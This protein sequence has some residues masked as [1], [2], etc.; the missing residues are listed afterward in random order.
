[1][2]YTRLTAAHDSAF[3]GGSVHA[4]LLHGD[5]PTLVDAPPMDVAFLDGIDQ[6][7]RAARD[8]P[9]APIILPHAH[10][11]PTDGATAVHSRW[12]Q[13]VCRKRAPM[14]EGGGIDWQVIEKEPMRP[15]GDGEL[16][17]LHTPGHAPDHSCLFDIHA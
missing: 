14:P 15:A 2:R 11:D 12:P 8:W 4:Y 5:V 16:W 9:L 3:S 17:V 6:A 7:L 10:P 1:M 13:A